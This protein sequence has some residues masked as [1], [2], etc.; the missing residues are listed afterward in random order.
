[1][2]GP[3]ALPRRVI[4]PKIA[5]V[6]GL[7]VTIATAGLLVAGGHAGAA[8]AGSHAR[9]ADT[10]AGWTTIFRDDFNGNA[11][12]G[13]S[14]TNWLYDTGT[15]YPGGAPNWGTGEVET[16]TDSTANVFRDGDGHLVIRP[17]RDAN[18]GWTSGRIETQRTDFAVPI[19]GQLKMTASIRQPNPTSGLGYWPAFWALG[20]AARPVSAT[21]WP[22]VGEFDVM[23]DVNGLSKV[24][25]TL[26]CGSWGQPP[27]NEPD[28]ITSGLLSCAG[29]QT[30]YHTYSVIL[31]RTNPNSEQLRFY[32]DNTQ[33][34]TVNESQV[35]ATTWAN[36]VDH[37]FFLILDVAIGGSY[38]NK[39]CGCNSLATQPSSGAG[40][41][42]DYV[43]VYQTAGG[44]VT[45]SSTATTSSTPTGSAST[46]SA[47]SALARIQAES[48]NA[49]AGTAVETTSDTGGGQ[50]VGWI[51]NGDWLQY[52]NVDFGSSPLTQFNARIA[53]GAAGGVSGLV[54]VHLDSPSS[55]S[56][57]S[58]A[59][60][61]TG[62][63][64][65]WRTVPANIAGTTGRHTVYL[66]FVSGSD[67]DF[68]NLN[69]FTFS[70]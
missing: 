46:D 31:D 70:P 33:D 19:G 30:A 11:N 63:W 28:G 48:D 17:L 38:P 3:S 7:G 57:G 10:P 27:C 16:A 61:N 34:F 24:S 43:A 59:I 13:V 18:G 20:A 52:N 2:P 47:V 9:A 67:Q 41:S 25:H 37:G 42:V 64:Q 5:L 49:Q 54:E 45:S 26:H 44:A 40:M 32:T 65:S 53:S 60:A 58:F 66:K 12:A 23:E 21:N 22:S 39:V 68:V 14:T 51:G 35:G 6:A 15:S 8:V 4:R 29:C 1:M 62:G 36:A 69:W 55:P 56:I 50:D